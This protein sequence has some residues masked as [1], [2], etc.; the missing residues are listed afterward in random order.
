MPEQTT[1]LITAADTLLAYTT[2]IHLSHRPNTFIIALLDTCSPNWLW[3]LLCA[4]RASANSFVQPLHINAAFT[5]KN[6]ADMVAQKW[7][8][9]IDVVIACPESNVDPRVL[10]SAFTPVL[11]QEAKVLVVRKKMEEWCR[12]FVVQMHRGSGIVGVGVE[13]GDVQE[14]ELRERV[15]W[16][17]GV[18]DR[19]DKTRGAG[20]VIAWD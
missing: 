3:R 9:K 16:V 2:I 8:R 10:M 1:Y 12:D 17:L 6:A 4:G 15:A 13:I 11:K 5:L 19:L 14:V 18:M 20:S 7:Q